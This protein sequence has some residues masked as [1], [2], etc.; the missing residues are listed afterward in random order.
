MKPSYFIFQTLAIFIL[1][2]LLCLFLPWYTFVIVAFISGVVANKQGFMS[3]IAGFVGSSLFYLVVSLIQARKD[4]FAFA[5]QIGEILGGFADTHISGITL[6]T[7]GT[8]IFGLLGGFFAWSGTL[9]LTNEP[10][11]RLSSGR[12]KNRTKSLKLDLKKYS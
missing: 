6:L 10:S 1:S 7:I 4:S 2:W 11:N 12:G 5:N 3:F 9:I 8:L